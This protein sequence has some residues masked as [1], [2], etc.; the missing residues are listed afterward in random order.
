MG[1]SL[2][3]IRERHQKLCDRLPDGAK[4]D[5][6]FRKWL[7][8]LPHPFTAAD[9]KAGY[10]YDLSILQAEFSLTMVLDRPLTGEPLLRGGHPRKPRPRPPRPRPVD[11][12][13]QDQPPDSGPL[14]H[15]GHYRGRHSLHSHRLQERTGQG[16]LLDG[17]ALRVCETTINN[18][19]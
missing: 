5:A 1:S 12:R 14:P 16:V 11:L 13:P 7:A 3:P 17:W 4:I 2:V 8:R 9:R 15:P 6:L 18:S 10:R 19:R